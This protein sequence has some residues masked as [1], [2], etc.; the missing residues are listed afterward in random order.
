MPK[1][2][3]RVTPAVHLILEREGKLFLMRRFNTGWE[4]GNYTLPSGHLEGGETVRESMLREALEETGIRIASDNLKMVHLMH[5][6]SG[7]DERMD[8]FFRANS[9][10]GEPAN[11]EPNKCDDAGWF[12]ALPDNTISYVRYAV[13]NIRSGVIYSEF[14]FSRSSSRT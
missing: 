7:D 12:V 6:V 2:R 4:D 14:G 13:E 11:A 5:R 10:E 3:F 9:W 8:F 1:E